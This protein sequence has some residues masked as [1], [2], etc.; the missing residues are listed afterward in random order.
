MATVTENQARLEQSKREIVQRYP[1]F[2]EKLFS[3]LER[4][5]STICWA[6]A[7]KGG[8]LSALRVAPSKSIANQF[9]ID[10][11]IPVLIANFGDDTALQP[12]V[13]RHLD[14]PELRSSTSADQNL[15]ILVASDRSADR[16][17]KDRK[18]FS[19]PI[20]TI[21]VDDLA[22]G[23]F[24]DTD[25]RSEIASL[26]RSANHFDYSNEIVQSADFFGRIDDKEAL[27]R[28]AS[29]GQSVGVFGLRRAGK[30]SLLYRVREE[31]ARK[32]IESIYIQLNLVLDAT[33]LREE[34]VRATAKL[35]ETR[36]GRVP[37]NSEM[38]N[39]D[40]TLRPCESVSRR[41]IYEMDALLDQID[42]DVV[43]MLDETDRANEESM[44]FADE[45]FEVRRQ[46]HQVLQQLRGLIQIRNQRSKRRL[47]FLTAGVAASIF[48]NAI[49]FG[50]DNQLFGFASARPLGPM[51]RDEMRE[52]VRT[53]GKR[54]GLKFD[55]HE[56]FDSLQA[57]YGGHPHL[58]RQAC[59]RVAENVQATQTS[60]VPH[61][62]TL[63]DLS[64]VYE[65]TAENAPSHAA[66]QT[67]RS[68]ELWY[69]KE[70]AAVR[71]AVTS[72]RPADADNIT[73][74]IDFGLCDR[75]GSVR[76]R[77]LLKALRRGV[78]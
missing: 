16:F 1:L 12:R 22:N 39:S 44:P 54:S 20:L 48:T 31:L 42:S 11:E 8:Q 46:M 73:H 28:L 2:A 34:L 19:Y 66:T 36:E 13:L 18:R 41:W 51:S 30:T 5:Q 14:A 75:D 67:F 59:A 65:S 45:G 15:A 55:G 52:M 43:V 56:I 10:L 6:R 27:T 4:D 32:N 33:G 35:L 17:T 68:F 38:L 29:G 3:F 9:E 71:E 49:R 60:E 58:T 74:A 24:T 23:Q 72:G 25:L 69:P 77:A 62:V 61:R 37:S 50:R 53:L 21:Y 7:W 26:M 47:S 76:Q 63:D 78:G 64:A 57:E 40:F 70:A